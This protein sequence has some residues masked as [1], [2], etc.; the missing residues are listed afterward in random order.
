M[1][2]ALI[3]LVIIE[4]TRENYNYKNAQL[5]SQ[6]SKDISKNIPIPKVGVVVDDDDDIGY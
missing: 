2:V 4:T 1:D 5:W 3:I 6:I